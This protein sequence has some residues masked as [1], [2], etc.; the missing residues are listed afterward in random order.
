MR[1]G[2]FFILLFIHL[3]VYLFI[4][5]FIHWLVCLFTYLLVS[6]SRIPTVE[7][8]NCGGLIKGWASLAR[9]EVKCTEPAGAIHAVS[10]SGR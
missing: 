3:F 7:S 8:L 1:L 6:G 5:S 2:D 10:G 9:V 4:Q